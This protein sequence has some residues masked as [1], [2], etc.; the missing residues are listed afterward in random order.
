MKLM[1]F[2][3]KD[4]LMERLD[5]S[6]LDHAAALNRDGSGPT[7]LEVYKL[8]ELAELHCYLKTVHRFE[9]AEVE[10]LLQFSDPLAV[11]VECWEERDSAK[12]FPICSLL[13]EI[14]A[15]ERFP[16]VDPVGRAQKEA[17]QIQTLKN[18][19]DQ[20]MSQFQAELLGMDK[21]EIIAKSAEIASMREAY[22]FMKEDFKF[23]RGDAE[24]LLRM[25]NPLKFVANQWPSDIAELFDMNDQVGEAIT[26]AGKEAAIQRDAEPVTP[27]QKQAI[28]SEVQATL[29][30]LV[31]TDL[32]LYGEVTGDTLEAIQTQGFLLHDYILQKADLAQPGAIQSG[33]EPA[34]KSNSTKTSLREQLHIKKQEVGQHSPQPNKAKGDGAR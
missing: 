28:S 2:E 8:Q 18:L 26:D 13:N 29:Q 15:Y 34:A 31:D 6:L 10:D 27:E 22:A 21:A 30:M 23:E 14:K 20:N 3:A 11:A 12:G 9:P 17:D 33:Q 4:L 32:R 24:I 7:I 5:K 19:L 25:E 1:E 16:L